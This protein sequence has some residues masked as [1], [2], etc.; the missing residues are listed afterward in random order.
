MLGG[1]HHGVLGNPEKMSPAR[2]L[3]GNAFDL[4]FVN[5]TQSSI[6]FN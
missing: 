6:I 2:L 4:K 5:Y 1:N 3:A